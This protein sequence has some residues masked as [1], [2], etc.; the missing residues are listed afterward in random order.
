MA[1]FLSLRVTARDVNTLT[2][3]L[4]ARNNYMLKYPAGKMRFV[5]PLLGLSKQ[6]QRLHLNFTVPSHLGW[7]PL[8]AYMHSNTWR[9][10][11]DLGH[12]DCGDTAWQ[13][14]Y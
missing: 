12:E 7:D 4:C 14:E 9:L 8:R 11:L 3:G 5:R 6:S 2:T 1:N 13:T 10:L